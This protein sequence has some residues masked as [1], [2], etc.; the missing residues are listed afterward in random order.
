MTDCID[1][2]VTQRLARLPELRWPE[3]GRALVLERLCYLGDSLLT[4]GLGGNAQVNDALWPV[5]LP[6]T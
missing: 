1:C 6:D 3:K 5:A 2:K 4:L